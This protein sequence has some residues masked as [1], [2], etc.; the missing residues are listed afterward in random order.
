MVYQIYW[1]H[2]KGGAVVRIPEPYDQEKGLVEAY[3]Q[4]ADTD[5]LQLGDAAAGFCYI[6]RKNILFIR[7]GDVMEV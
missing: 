4:A 6:L 3:R 1:I 7:T 2:L 5:V